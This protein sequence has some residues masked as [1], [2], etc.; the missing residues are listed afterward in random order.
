MKKTSSTRTLNSPGFTLVELLLVVT[1]VGMLAAVA[2]PSLMRSIDSADSAVAYGQLRAIHSN[3]AIFLSQ[4]Q[5]YAR[6]AELNTFTNES[7]GRTD[8][9]TLR[10]RDFVF[11]MLP[12]PTN[13]SLRSG[14]T[15]IANRIKQ[16]RIV[17]QYSIA[18]KGLIETI[19]P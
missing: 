5:R 9:S 16:G 14:F 2:I 17:S 8:G 4:R 1:I 11:L 13:D 3:Q 18:E 12:N 19:L 15:I 7:L 10:H 6:L